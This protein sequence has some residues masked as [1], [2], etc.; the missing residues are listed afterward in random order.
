MSK[1]SR[2][3]KRFQTKQA[4]VQ[5]ARR[6]FA[7]KNYSLK[8]LN[9]FF[10]TQSGGGYEGA[11]S[12][13]G[14][15]NWQYTQGL[16]DSEILGDLN[17]LRER[18]RDLYRNNA[19]GRGAIGTMVMN[20]IG[21]GLHLQSAIDREYLGIDDDIADAWET[22][23]ERKFD[24]WATAKNCDAARSSNFYDLEWL[25]FMSYLQSGEVFA[26][27]PLLERDGR[28]QL[29]IQLIEADFVQNGPGQY[30]NKNM[31]DGIKVDEY[32]APIEYSIRTDQATWKSVKAYGEKTSR[33]NILHLFRQE[34]PGQSRGVPFL[35]SV[36]ENIKELGRY[37]KSEL[38][39]AVVSAM[40]TVFIKSNN[41]DALDNPLA[42]TTAPVTSTDGD[43]D[44]FDYTLAPAAVHHLEDN[45]DITFANPMRPNTAYEAFINAQLREIG[46]ALQIPYEI[47]AKQFLSSYS[48]SRASRIEAWR[49]F[50]TERLKFARDFC[51]VIYEEWLT[52]EILQARIPAGGFF[53]SVDVKKAWCVAEWNGETMGQ[54]DEQKEVNAAILKVQ[55]GFSTYQ[56]E[57]AALNGGD[58]QRNTRKLKRERAIL[59]MSGLI[60]QTPEPPAPEITMGEV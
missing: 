26:L 35:A 46:M 43:A 2:Q 13:R 38:A 30:T 10:Y 41:P 59:D 9:N 11:G 12:G 52:E 48:A 34:R 22:N 14:L 3:R 39:A 8:A 17:T 25:A 42:G 16:A 45:E 20:V 37:N 51:Q 15:K 21:S 27:L 49:F 60:P 36:L 58:F 24:N 29:C 33:P 7:E 53:S 1:R 57:T 44:Y 6:N 5:P 32:G 56:K 54:I 23:V 18:S 55:N 50:M 28:L 40:F 31:R 19:I 47:L 4:A